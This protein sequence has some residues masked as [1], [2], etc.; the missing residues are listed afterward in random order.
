MNWNITEYI[1]GTSKL[2]FKYVNKLAC[3]DLDGTLIC[4]KSGKIFPTHRNDWYFY[5]NNVC[6]KLKHLHDNGFCI[7]IITNQS[8]LKDKDKNKLDIWTGKVDD[9]VSQL[10]VPVRLFCSITHDIYRKPRPAF[11]NLIIKGIKSKISNESFYCGDA[12]GRKGDHADTD[13]K[14]A[15]NAGLR[16]I[17]PDEF[18]DNKSVT[19]PKI[20]YPAFDE[21]DKL[22]SQSNIDFKPMNKEI[23]IMVGPPGSGKSTFVKDILSPF[24][25]VRINRDSLATIAK[26][27]TETE[28]NL[29]QGNLIVIDNTNNNLE[30]RKKYIDLSLKY[31]YTARCII[32]DV[33][34]D[35]AIHNATYRCYKGLSEYIP[36]LVY[37][38]YYS[39]YVEPKVEEGF[40]EIIK[41]KPKINIV[42]S[43]YKMYMY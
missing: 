29:K 27:L 3:F 5:S 14:F 11:M 23:I 40:K 36:D 18:F 10:N 13:Y 34:R 30:T 33:S 12:C 35:L 15:L 9:V 4:T 26:C 16:F 1:S 39:K 7:V 28:K 38:M 21:I 31:N 25:Y 17:T 8:G 6:E 19:I 41:V 32:M 42:D 37:N 24:K 43:D 20:V 22:Q 2:N